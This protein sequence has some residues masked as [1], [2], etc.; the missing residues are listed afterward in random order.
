[1]D[2]K[3]DALWVEY[4]DACPEPDP[5]PEFMPRLWQQID[6]RRSGNARVLRR[7]AQICVMATIALTVLIGAV[8]IPHIQSEAFFSKS[9]VE[10]LAAEHVNADFTDFLTVGDLR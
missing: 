10:E 5:T 7:L 6:K 8:V 1:M 3:L 9:Y 2:E 4:R